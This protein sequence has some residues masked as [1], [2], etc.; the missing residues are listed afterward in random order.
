MVLNLTLT[1][2]SISNLCLS[3]LFYTGKIKATFS[4]LNIFN[5]FSTAILSE[6]YLYVSNSKFKNFLSSAIQ[7]SSPSRLFTEQ[8]T[9]PG[10]DP[11]FESDF[12]ERCKAPD[13]KNGGGIYCKNSQLNIK[14]SL[15]VYCES[16]GKGG[17]IYADLN[18]KNNISIQNTRIY[19]CTASEGSSFYITNAKDVSI[20]QNS[21]EE[22]AP[23]QRS[24]IKSN[25]FIITS[26]DTI[27]YVNYTSCHSQLSSASLQLDC[28]ES[29]TIGY[30]T[31]QECN[32]YNIFCLKGLCKS[33]SSLI[34]QIIM[35]NNSLNGISNSIGNDRYEGNSLIS[36][37]GEWRISDSYFI[38]DSAPHLASIGYGSVT[39]FR[40]T[41]NVNVDDFNSISNIFLLE[42][43]SPT[44]IIFPSIL[45]TVNALNFDYIQLYR[46]QTPRIDQKPPKPKFVLK[47]RLGYIVA[48]IVLTIVFLIVT[49]VACCLLKRHRN[50]VL[51]MLHKNY[52][53]EALNREE[54]GEDK[55]NDKDLVFVVDEND[56][57]KKELKKRD[58]LND[59]DDF[60]K[61][62]RKDNRLQF[63]DVAVPDTHLW[64]TDEG[65]VELPEEEAFLAD[66]NDILDGVEIKEK[67]K[68]GKK[69]KK[70]KLSSLIKKGKKKK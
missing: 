15:F 28:S 66:V 53:A 35:F 33:S 12:F 16:S 10:H 2:L 44:T 37:M 52:A 23:S 57:K 22:S 6:H 26:S 67:S 14:N 38:F 25:C 34:E 4:Y 31:F 51:V 1:A 18:D 41:F 68:K 27:K 55:I 43:R 36:I 3:P 21:I 5:S 65:D 7:I 13:Q 54:E 42:C 69:K 9:V 39:F 56:K 8:V 11:T 63:N 70:K 64:D 61:F 47:K 32:G 46:S 19:Y 58:L 62:T 49:I 45:F 60:Y 50:H 59:F 17:A 48:S 40:C 29:H 24:G 20:S 30:T